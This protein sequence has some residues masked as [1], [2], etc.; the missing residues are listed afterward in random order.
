MSTTLLVLLA[1]LSQ[2]PPVPPSPPGTAATAETPLL[3]SDGGPA[4]PGRIPTDSPQ[5]AVERWRRALAATGALDSPITAFD[6]TFELDLRHDGG[7]NQTDASFRFLDHPGGPYLRARLR[8]EERVTL[9]GPRGDFR[10]EGTSVERIQGRHFAEDERQL[11]EWVAIARNFVALTKPDGVRLV[12]LDPVELAAEQ[13]EGNT[14]RFDGHDPLPLP[15]A[16]LAADAR[17]LEW[18]LVTSPDFRLYETGRKS[19]E[20]ERVHRALLGTDPGSG[21]LRLA[22][23]DENRG[24]LDPSTALFVRVH[25]YTDVEPG[26]RVPAGLELRRAERAG[27]SWRFEARP[28]TTLW[29]KKGG[30]FNPPLTPADFLPPD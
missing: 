4:I 29:L 9:R 6:V 18:I 21:E 12:S 1:V 22:V 28:Q 3:A 20:P 11:D 14:V 15:D 16:A 10:L 13:G 5:V 23:L 8:S 27:M 17:A 2:D 25:R 19:G 7:F 24:R 30:R 26:Y